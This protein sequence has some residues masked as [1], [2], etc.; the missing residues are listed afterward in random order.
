[1]ELLIAAFALFL[2]LEGALYALFPAAMK[3]MIAE[4][5]RMPDDIIRNFGMVAAAIGLGALW[6]IYR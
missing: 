5:L 1:M 2:V 3:R 6:L 4:V